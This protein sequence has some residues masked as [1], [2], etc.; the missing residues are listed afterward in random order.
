MA[1]LFGYW[2]LP[3]TILGAGQVIWL[4]KEKALSQHELNW[5]MIEDRAFS[6]LIMFRERK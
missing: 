6:L 3:C 1:N 5:F 2:Y 4:L